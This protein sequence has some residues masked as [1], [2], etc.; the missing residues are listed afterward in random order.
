MKIAKREL[1]AAIILYRLYGEASVNLGLAIDTLREEL[2]VTK[3]VAMSIVKRLR[4]LGFLTVESDN[5]K[6]EVKVRNPCSVIEEYAL[7]YAEARKH[8]KAS[9]S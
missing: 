4:K 8:R 9:K 6:V 1:S 2:G 7:R 3:K 5:L